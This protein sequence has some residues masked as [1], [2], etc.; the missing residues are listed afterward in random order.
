M[1]YVAF[2]AVHDSRENLPDDLCSQLLREDS[3]IDDLVKELS[4]LAV[5]CDQ[6]E[7]VLVLVILQKTHY[8]WVFLQ[9][10]KL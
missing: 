1:Y 2:M 7:V 8:V 10:F 4:T 3:L 9:S 6:V 5:F